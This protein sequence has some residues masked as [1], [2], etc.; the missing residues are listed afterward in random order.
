MATTV[1]I[2]EAVWDELKR[3][4]PSSFSNIIG[5][6]VE[7]GKLVQV[8]QAAGAHLRHRSIIYT[9]PVD[10]AVIEEAMAQFRDE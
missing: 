8:R 4:C 9:M 2:I 6:R 5:M 7:N 1:E 3:Q 10:H